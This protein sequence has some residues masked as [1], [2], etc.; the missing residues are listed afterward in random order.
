M[1]S[2]TVPLTLVHSRDESV[3][4]WGGGI[5][6]ILPQTIQ[7][8]TS[9]VS[10]KWLQLTGYNAGLLILAEQDGITGLNWAQKSLCVGGIQYE[11]KLSFRNFPTYFKFA[12]AAAIML[13]S[14]LSQFCVSWV[15]ANTVS[16]LTTEL[17]LLFPKFCPDLAPAQPK[18]C[19]CCC[20]SWSHWKHHSQIWLRRDLAQD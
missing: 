1:Q 9:R 4:C 11:G 8:N 5:L 15:H 18:W 6:G 20:S 7:W 13:L 16:N 10:A 19:R 17:E 14:W 3:P 12:F 2:R